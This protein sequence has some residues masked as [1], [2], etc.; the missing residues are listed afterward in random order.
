[1]GSFGKAFYLG[2]KNHDF[3]ILT[4]SIVFSEALW[5]S[6]VLMTNINEG[7]MPFV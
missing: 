1:M 7:T 2:A 6:V 3:S 5:P 4:W